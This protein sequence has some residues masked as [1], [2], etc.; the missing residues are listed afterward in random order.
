MSTPIE[1]LKP[2]LDTRNYLNL[3][4]SEQ[5]APAYH[6][7]EEVE[8]ASDEAL[9][10]RRNMGPRGVTAIRKAIDGL[11]SG[12]LPMPAHEAR[13][14]SDVEAWIKRRRDELDGQAGGDITAEWMSLDSLL[15]DYRLHADTGTPLT[16]EVQGPHHGADL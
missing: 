16:E 7:V 11:R 5:W 8:G 3:R 12:H 13:R 1:A 9:L 14:G 2:Y 4:R 10:E 6:T 15:D